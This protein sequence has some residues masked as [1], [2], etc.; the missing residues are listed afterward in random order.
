MSPL[1]Y[2]FPPLLRLPLALALA[3]ALSSC[4]DGQHESLDRRFRV[5][6]ARTGKVGTYLGLQVLSNTRQLTRQMILKE[7]GPCQIGWNLNQAFELH[8]QIEL[9]VRHGGSERRFHEKGQLQ[10]NHD[11]DWHYLAHQDLQ[12]GDLQ[13]SRSVQ[14]LYTSDGLITWEGINVASRQRADESL[15]SERLQEMAGRFGALISL[16]SPG[17]DLRPDGSFGPGDSDVFCSPHTDLNARHWRPLFSARSELQHARIN[18]DGRCRTLQA[19][20]RLP[21]PG[22][23]SLRL[24]ECLQESSGFF[25]PP[26]P[27]RMIEVTRHSDRRDLSRT[28]E[29]LLDTG[30]IAP[31]V[32][33]SPASERN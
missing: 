29:V 28:L 15:A 10:Q 3:F 12:D 17:W 9:T 13:T 21:W 23:M 4:T 33:P 18:N 6:P 27:D 20:F 2:D 11:R 7:D 26:L 5:D 31:T 1:R 22:S 14:L 25:P 32:S 30:V 24:Q 8:H 16:I 19:E